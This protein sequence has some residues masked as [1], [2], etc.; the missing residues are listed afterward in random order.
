MTRILII[1]DDVGIRGNTAELLQLE[2]YF[3]SAASNGRTGL[4][5]IKCETPDL[6]LCDILMPEMDGFAVLRHVGQDP[7]LKRIPFIFFSA[8]SEK[9][10]IKAGIDAGAD[11]YLTKPFELEDLLTTIEKHVN[12]QKILKK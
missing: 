6:I 10:D 9:I 3:V 4:E 7:D 11:D 2:G 8:K 12:K 5:K 1:E